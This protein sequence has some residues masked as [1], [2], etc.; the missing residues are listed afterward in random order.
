MTLLVVGSIGLDTVR[1]PFGDVADALGGSATYFSTAA[2]FFTDTALVGVVG[3]DFP[4][5]H[6]LFL[7]SREIDLAGLMTRP[8]RTFRWSGSYGYQLNEA[9]TLA[10]HLNVFEEFRPVLPETYRKAEAVFLANIDPDLQM[11]VL[12]HVENPWLVAS[13]TMNFWIAGKPD[14][15]RRMLARVKVLLVNDGEA[16]QLSGE[17]N[18]VRAARAIQGM[19]PA[20][21]II[22]RG[23]YGALLFNGKSVFAAPAYPLETIYDPTG[24]GDTFAGG[25]MGYLSNA[26]DLSEPSL[27]RAIIYGSAMASFTV[28]AFSLDRLKALSYDEIEDRFRAFQAL[29]AFEPLLV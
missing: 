27:R 3:E 9:Q 11:E 17:Y 7:K 18:L 21:V 4:A 20:V 5:E 23:E 13:D 14:A 2:S 24:A 26:R 15:L 6:C 12:D 1:T 25:F 22:K 16:R 28:E 19:G 10:T 29:T 8:G